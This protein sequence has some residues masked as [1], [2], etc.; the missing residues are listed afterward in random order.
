[1]D[2]QTFFATTA[3]GLTELLVSELETMGATTVKQSR[4]G[5]YFSGGLSIA[6]RAC[7]WSRLAS[8]VEWGQVHPRVGGLGGQGAGW[9]GR[10]P[11]I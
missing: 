3:K 11:P 9:S 1:M 8:A 10:E 4:T 5:V 2:T 7:L 6:Y